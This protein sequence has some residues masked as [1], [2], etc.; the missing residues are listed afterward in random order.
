MK[1]M[2][3]LFLVMLFS[4][5]SWK[6]SKSKSPLETGSFQ[7]QFETGV[8]N[9]TLHFNSF[10]KNSVNESFTVGL[11][12]Y[13]IS[14]LRLRKKDGG[15]VMLKDTYFLIDAE[16]SNKIEV[17]NVPSG[18]YDQISFT[19]GI[20]SLTTKKGN[21]SGVLDPINGMF[22]NTW[23]NYINFMM[24]GNYKTV[25]QKI[26]T[27][28]YHIGGFEGKNNTVQTIN[29][30]LNPSQLVVSKITS[31]KVF[32]SM[33]VFKFFKSANTISIEKTPVVSEIGDSAR[34]VSENFRHM[35]KLKEIVN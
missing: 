20:D 18:N 28:E 12:K 19:L 10:Y 25:N 16:Y 27:Y 7:I 34:I 15:E 4:A 26:K 8:E 5:G 6:S 35:F 13:Y 3:A 2:Y 29:L 23:G 14:N 1:Y 24:N 33:D 31:P 30:E 22:W 21:Y 17:M 9:K 32:I 11:L